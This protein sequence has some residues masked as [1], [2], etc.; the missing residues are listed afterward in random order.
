MKNGKAIGNDKLSKEMIE[1]CKDLGAEK[2]L[3]PAN[4]IYNSGIIARQRKESVFITI[5]KKGDLLDCSNYR[6]ISLISHITKVIL[7]V[8]MNRFKK[9]KCQES[10]GVSLDLRRTRERGTQYSS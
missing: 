3:N 6:L 8:I 10:L 5:P 4:K 1:A 2:I 7:R 9:K